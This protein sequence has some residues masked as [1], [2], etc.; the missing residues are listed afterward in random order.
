MKLRTVLDWGI[1]PGRR[2]WWRI[3]LASM[4]IVAAWAGRRPLWYGNL[5]VVEPGRVYRSAQ[6]SPGDWP[7]LR[8]EIAPASVLNLRGGWMGDPWYA[9]EVEQVGVDVYDYRISA[10]ERPK[11]RELLALLD[12]FGR[13]RYP[14]LIHCKSGSDRTGLASGLYL[15]DRRGMPPDEARRALSLAYGH[16][17]ALGTERMHAPFREYSAWLRTRGLEHNPGRLRDWVA[18]EY[19]DDDPI[20]EFEPLRPVSPGEIPRVASKDR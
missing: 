17:P 20:A 10:T 9:A 1:W 15:M 2:R 16:F 13:C 14:L 12:L 11:R 4:L 3:L 6:P 7:R 19:L 5:G 8:A 18:R